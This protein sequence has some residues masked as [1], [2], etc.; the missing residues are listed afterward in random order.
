MEMDEAVNKAV[1]SMRLFQLVD[2]WDLNLVKMFGKELW[3]AGYDYR[4]RELSAHHIK[5]IEQFDLE[6][7]KIGEF[8]SIKEAAKETKC[9]RDVIDEVLYGQRHHTSRG[10]IWKY[11]ET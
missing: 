1:M 10:H 2:E 9:C 6:G 7:K 8:D 11:A 4:G 3:A 5:K